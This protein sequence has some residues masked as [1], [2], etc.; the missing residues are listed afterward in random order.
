MK[1][2]TIPWILGRRK[3]RTKVVDLQN[4]MA[5]SKTGIEERS[6]CAM[7]KQKGNHHKKYIMD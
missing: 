6:L 4:T 5:G 2:D 7:E 3:T 1:I